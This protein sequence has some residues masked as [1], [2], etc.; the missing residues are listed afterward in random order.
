MGQ[1]SI[2]DQD[3]TGNRTTATVVQALAPN[4]AI[5]LHS[6]ARAHPGCRVRAVDAANRVVDIR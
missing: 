1:V 5:A 3:R 2:Q 4:I 6:T